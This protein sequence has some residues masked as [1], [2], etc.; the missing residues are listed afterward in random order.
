[1]ADYCGGG[2]G[3]TEQQMTE[4]V[5]PVGEGEV[6]QDDR[7]EDDEPVWLH[8][9]GGH[10][11]SSSSSRGGSSSMLIDPCSNSTARRSDSRLRRHAS[12]TAWE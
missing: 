7:V 5:Q 6:I 10:G 2:A 12:M 3:L 4:H 9:V 1:M 8:Q 11:S